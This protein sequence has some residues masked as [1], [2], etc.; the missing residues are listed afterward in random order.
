MMKPNDFCVN[1]VNYRCVWGSR[2]NWDT[3][4]KIQKDRKDKIVFCGIVEERGKG[5]RY[6][7]LQDDEQ[8]INYLI[9]IQESG[10]N[11]ATE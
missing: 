4:N 3:L 9:A 10:Q 5:S 8:G 7:W 11:G 1:D 2:T 6:V